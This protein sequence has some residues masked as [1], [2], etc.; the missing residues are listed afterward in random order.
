MCAQRYLV[1]SCHW[2]YLI[3]AFLIHLRSLQSDWLSAVRFMHDSHY[4][5]ALNRTSARETKALKQN[6]K[7]DFKACIKSQSNYRK[8]SAIY[9]RSSL[10]TYIASFF[11]C[12]LHTEM[13]CK[14]KRVTFWFCFLNK[15]ATGSIKN[16]GTYLNPVLR[17]LNCAISE[18]ICNK[19]AI[20][21]CA[22]QFSNRAVRSIDFETTCMIS[23]QIAFHSV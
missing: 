15:P 5:F 3:I 17:R 14:L 10:Y 16:T 1:I 21:L 4:F 8:A 7:S 13:R 19:V 12:A 22:V 23:D 2:L 6:K 11:V 9:L 20:K 18:W